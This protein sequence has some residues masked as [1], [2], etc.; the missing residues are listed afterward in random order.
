MRFELGL[1]FQRE[2]AKDPPPR[3]A[4]TLL[5]GGAKRAAF[6]SAKSFLEA[7]VVADGGEV[8]VSTRVLAE[9]RKQ[10]DRPS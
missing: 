7:W 9:P 10:L 1:K 5:D 2:Y 8:F 6:F 3:A 4:D